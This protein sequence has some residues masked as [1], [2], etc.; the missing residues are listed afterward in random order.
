MNPKHTFLLNEGTWNAKGF[1]FDENEKSF[2]AEGE[3][4]I[5][6]NENTWQVSNWI[7]TLGNDPLEIR[8]EYEVT[9]FK[10][11]GKTAFWK[12]ENPIFGALKGSF[13]IHGEYIVSL[14]ESEDKIYSGSEY[15]IF[16][17]K[18]HYRYRGVI[19]GADKKYASWTLEMKISN[20]E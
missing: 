2:A 10:E 16:V 5:K 9:P 8:N 11:N 3:T 17:D 13:L 15:L 14:F 7:K 20:N 4:T 19:F 18:K 12:S 6:H 1:Y